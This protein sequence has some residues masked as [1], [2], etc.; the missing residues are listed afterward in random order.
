MNPEALGFYTIENL[1]WNGGRTSADTTFRGSSK[2][3]PEAF[4][5]AI[6]VTAS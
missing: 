3:N 1:K 6:F 2:L 4:K 5:A